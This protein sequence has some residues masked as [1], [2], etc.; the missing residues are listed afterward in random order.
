MTAMS[1]IE[2]PQNPSA[3][4]IG[5]LS[6]QWIPNDAFS[7]SVNDIG[8]RQGITVVERLRTYAGRPFAVAAHLDRWQHSTDELEIEG[9]PCRDE[10]QSLLQIL[11]AKNAATISDQTDV[12]ITWF[13]TPG[14]HTERGPTFGMHLNPLDHSVNRSRRAVGQPIVLTDI[15]QPAPNC[16][17][18]TIK[19]RSRIHYYRADIAA[20]KHAL[21]AVGLLIDTDETVTE[22]SIANL[23][24]VQAGAIVSPPDGQVLKGISQSIIETL[25]RKSGLAWEKRAIS[26]TELFQADEVLLMGTDTGIWFGNRL[27]Q[28]AGPGKKPVVKEL[29]AGPL[30]KHLHDSFDQ[31]ARQ[32]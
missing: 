29:S 3:L 23:A 28:G 12:G 31:W 16:W 22:T 2:V 27:I 30:Y 19:T 21:D 17:P 6:G 18:R 26:T 24:M 10:L 15:A 25:A 11:L 13:A 1:T 20:R 9:L 5:Y 14:V 7:L 4:W 32:S 8:F